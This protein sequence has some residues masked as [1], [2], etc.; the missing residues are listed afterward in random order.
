MNCDKYKKKA[1]YGVLL[2]FS[3]II[4]A[5][6]KINLL[7]YILYGLFVIV[8]GYIFMSP[9]LKCL[10]EYNKRTKPPKYR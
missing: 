6:L 10:Q 9:Y 8:Y 3:L 5:V 1:V 4:F 7:V 2:I